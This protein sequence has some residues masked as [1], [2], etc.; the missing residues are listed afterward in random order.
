M[1]YLRWYRQVLALDIRNEHQVDAIVPRPD[2]LVALSMQTP[3]GP[4]T[5]LARRVVLATGRDG[6]GGAYL[7]PTVGAFVRRNGLR[8]AARQARGRGRRRRFGHGQR[9]DRAGSRRRLRGD[10]DP[11][12]RHPARQQGQGRGQSRPGP[13]PHHAVR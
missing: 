2:G 4:Q 11:P 12:R 10:A 7:P 1:D 9:G 5:V 8:H 3:D 13:R 6:L